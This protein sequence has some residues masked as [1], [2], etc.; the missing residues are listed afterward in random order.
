[1]VSQPARTARATVPRVTGGMTHSR[2]DMR[3]GLAA[4]F[5]FPVRCRKS[6]MSR[7]PSLICPTRCPGWRTGPTPGRALRPRPGRKPQAPA[8]GGGPLAAVNESDR[9]GH[10]VLRVVIGGPGCGV[11][12]FSKA[13]PG[14]VLSVESPPPLLEVSETRCVACGPVALRGRSL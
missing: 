12:V 11:A 7:G 10:D 4:D 8:G 6:G 9:A 13:R 1:M 14:A 3:R 5:G 2:S